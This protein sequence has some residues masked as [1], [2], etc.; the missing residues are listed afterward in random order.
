MQTKFDD[1]S[2]NVVGKY[3]AISQTCR[4][5]EMSGKINDLEASLN[6]LIQEAEA[7][8]AALDSKSPAKP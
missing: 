1:M 8:S 6:K 7:D 3:P 5:D 4:I 2:K